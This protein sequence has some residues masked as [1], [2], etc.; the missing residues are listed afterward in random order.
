MYS[1]CLN[2]RAIVAGS[3]RTYS[4]RTPDNCDSVCLFDG[5]SRPAIAGPSMVPRWVAMSVTW[6]S[7]R[8]EEG[9]AAAG[10]THAR[11]HAAKWIRIEG[12]GEGAERFA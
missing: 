3:E 8:D 6:L 10:V 5:A 9:A 2:S 7:G 11:T 4:A 1:V 12:A